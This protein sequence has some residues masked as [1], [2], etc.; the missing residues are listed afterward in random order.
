MSR[1]NWVRSASVRVACFY[2][3]LF[4]L[5]VVTIFG[6]CYI[7]VKSEMEASLASSIDKDIAT[8]AAEYKSNGISMLQEGVDERVT[9]T[10]GLDRIYVLLNANGVVLS[11]NISAVP[12]GKATYYGPVSESEKTDASSS[13]LNHAFGKSVTLGEYRLFVGRDATSMAETL[14][15]LFWAFVTGAIF[16]ALAALLLGLMLGRHSTRR[17][18]ALGQTTQDIVASG[19]KNR[20]PLHGSGDEIDMISSEFNLVLDRLQSLV[21]G[22]RRITDDIAH[23]LRTPLSRLRQKLEAAL[24][25]ESHNVKFYRTSIEQAAKESDGIMDTFSALLRIAQI[26]G[27]ARRGSFAR[28]NLSELLESVKEIYE[29][30]LEDAKLVFETDIQI[31]VFTTGD[32]ELLV[33]LFAN[34][35]ENAVRHG[36]SGGAVQ[37][38]LAE[39]AGRITVTIADHGPGIPVSEH[40]KVFQRLYRGD[41]SRSSKG[42]GLGLS[43]VAAIADLHGARITLED[44]KPGLRV[45]LNMGSQFPLEARAL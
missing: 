38:F 23:D 14:E 9:E 43:L 35:I 20:I 42:H 27:G 37:L 10:Q 8:L 7:L 21:D 45:L 32:R 1:V 31:G 6:S 2:A 13:G 16:T 12:A 40:D 33:Q 26:E 29:P 18:R 22:V 4:L 30:V 39:T 3:A 19:M 25:S 41:K 36:H 11:G 28:L 24:D 34:L 44:N 15:T 17:I 5:S